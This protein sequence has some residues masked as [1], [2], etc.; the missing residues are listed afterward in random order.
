MKL[1][2]TKPS[3]EDT[4]RKSLKTEIDEKLLELSNHWSEQYKEMQNDLYY[5]GSSEG[6]WETTMFNA[7]KSESRPTI[8]I[9]LSNAYIEKMSSSVRTNP[10]SIDVKTSDKELQAVVGGILRGI[11]LSSKSS[12]AYATGIHNSATCG[13]G[14]LRLAIEEGI[15][16]KVIKIKSVLNPLSIMIDPFSEEV[17][18]SDAKYAVH[19]GAMDEDYAKAKYGDDICGSS[20]YGSSFQVPNGSVIDVTCYIVVDEGCKIIRYIGNKIVFETTVTGL[21]STLVFPVIGNRIVTKS[22]RRFN[23]LVAKIKDLNTSVNITFSNVMEMVALAPKAPFIIHEEAIEGH[24]STWANANSGSPAYLPYKGTDS[25]GNAIPMPQRLD[26][27]PQTQAL[28]AVGDWA[29]G[30]LGRVT[31]IS[32]GML[33]QLQTAQESEGKFISRMENGS[34]GTA[35][36]I[37]HLTTSITQM[38]RVIIKCLPIVYDTLRS[39]TIVDEFGRSNKVKVD[40]S[41][42]LTPEIIDMLD[43]EVE[44][45][46]NMEMNRRQSQVALQTI[47][48][49]SGDKG[50]AF[51]DLWAETQNLPNADKIQER[52]KMVM[53]SEFKP[54]EGDIPP[55]AQQALQM[56]DNAIQ[57]K[58]VTIQQLQAMLGQLQAQVNNQDSLVAVEKYKADLSASTTLRKAE[59][60]YE[61]ELLKMDNSNLQLAEK[62]SADQR[63]QV[64]EFI[65]SLAK[66]KIETE[67]KEPQMF[68]DIPKVPQYMVED[69]VKA[70][71]NISSEQE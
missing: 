23:G 3:D 57:E 27:Q 29:I 42:Y 53:P 66:T 4:R 48:Q 34:A 10:P 51:L 45:G 44:S 60:E 63:K 8:S 65:A 50:L 1:D 17:D 20:A 62:L 26:N 22:G 55:E 32:D 33:G 71:A 41:E 68:S 64:N 18:G 7:R 21:K 58:D 49:Q 36:Y 14:W 35:M 13:L 52:V 28:Q 56:A 59:M 46:A 25:Q 19:F 9:P 38:A 37:D 5:V 30:L 12:E 69:L 70:Q 2:L 31:G 15:G 40:L 16:G 61:K 54:S 47:M 39:I 67:N 11:E 24:K 6:M 43:V